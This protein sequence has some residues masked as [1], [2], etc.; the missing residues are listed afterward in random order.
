MRRLPGDPGLQV[1]QLTEVAASLPAQ[2][3]SQASSWKSPAR[4]S[5]PSQLGRLT[6][7]DGS[8]RPV[9]TLAKFHGQTKVPLKNSESNIPRTPLLAHIGHAAQRVPWQLSGVKRT[10]HFDRGAA[11]NDPSR[12][13]SVRRSGSSW[14]TATQLPCKMTARRQC[15][16]A[17]SIKRTCWPLACPMK[18]KQDGSWKRAFL[19][20]RW[21][22]A[23]G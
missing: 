7:A 10:S 1:P 23:E 8:L 21:R 20:M 14:L 6:K 13:R 2:S 11:A 3:L 17:K 5:Q 9:Q 19:P 16:L 18:T 4:C 22:Q 15:G 12:K